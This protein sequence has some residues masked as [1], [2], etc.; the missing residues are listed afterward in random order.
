[1]IFRSYNSMV[2]KLVCWETNTIILVI[3]YFVYI[4]YIL[5]NYFMLYANLIIT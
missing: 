2:K 5:L 1:M 3:H 4:P